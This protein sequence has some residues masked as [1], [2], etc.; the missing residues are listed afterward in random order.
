MAAVRGFG[1]VL[2]VVSAMPSLTG[3]LVFGAVLGLAYSRLF[4][5]QAAP[6][7]AIASDWFTLTRSVL[8]R[9]RCCSDEKGLRR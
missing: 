4:R 2:A 1:R 5:R 3:H 7:A 8:L 9:G 6:V